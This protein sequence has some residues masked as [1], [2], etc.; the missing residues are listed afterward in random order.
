MLEP[1]TGVIIFNG[2]HLFPI[3]VLWCYILGGLGSIVGYVRD[4]IKQGKSIHLRGLVSS[5]LLSLSTI[6]LIIG[7]LDYFLPETSNHPYLYFIVGYFNR[8]INAY[9]ERN[10]EKIVDKFFDKGI[11][12]TLGIDTND[13]NTKDQGGESADKT[14]NP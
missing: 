3:K 8:Y 2:F 4:R 6:Y 5:F 1:A 10:A 13:L 9:I 11:Q 14:N 12:K 7:A